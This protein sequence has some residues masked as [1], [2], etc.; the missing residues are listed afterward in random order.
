MWDSKRDTD[1]NNR[2]LDSGKSQGL[3][4]LREY[5]WDIYITICEIDDQSKFDA[6][7]KPLKVGALGQPRGMEWGRRGKGC[8]GCGDTCT[9]E[10]DSSQYMAKTT[11]V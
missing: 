9:P 3:D 4:D 1:I 5:H 2:L 11:I 6:W 7:N 8:S 10:A